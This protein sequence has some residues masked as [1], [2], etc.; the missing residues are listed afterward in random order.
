MFMDVACEVENPPK[1]GDLFEKAPQR[2]DDADEISLKAGKT[3]R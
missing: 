2:Y 3:G 1:V